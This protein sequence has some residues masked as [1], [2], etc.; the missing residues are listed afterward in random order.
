MV[1]RYEAFGSGNENPDVSHPEHHIPPFHVSV[2]YQLSIHKNTLQG[3][4]ETQYS[5]K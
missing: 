5:I 2:K 4:Y 1:R 3:K